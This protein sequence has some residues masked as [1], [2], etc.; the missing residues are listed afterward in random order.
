[1]PTIVA[2]KSFVDKV[3]ESVAEAQIL[4]ETR[5]NRDVIER[6]YGPPPAPAS[7]FQS[8]PRLETNTL[9]S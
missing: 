6:M 5:N 7:G 8:F 3:M 9:R 1:M 2:S 4:C